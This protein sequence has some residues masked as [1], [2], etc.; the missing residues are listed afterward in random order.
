MKNIKIIMAMV[1]ATLM[2]LSI[3]GCSN[4]ED[5]T[6]IGDIE[7]ELNLNEEMIVGNLEYAVNEAGNYEIVGFVYTGSKE[8]SATI[9]AKISGRPVTGIGADAFK[10]ATLLASVTF[11][12]GCA[13]EYIGDFA[14]YGCELLKTV[15]IPA[16]VKEIGEGAFWGCTALETVAMPESLETVGNYAFWGCKALKSVDLP[17]REVVYNSDTKEYEGYLNIGEGAFFDCDALTEVTLPANTQTVGKGAFIYCDALTSVIFKSADTELGEGV[18][19]GSDGVKI[20]AP[21]ESK[22]ATYAAANGIELVAA[23]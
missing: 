19:A 18:F 14:F 13:I 6:N 8:V 10:S 20:T 17:E 7:D 4:V 1:L 22:A 11:E 15:T 5:Q 9:P 23:Q 21:A 12:E 16:S 3:V 2:A